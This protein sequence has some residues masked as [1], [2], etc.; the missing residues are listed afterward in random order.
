MKRSKIY[1]VASTVALAVVGFISAKAHQH[2]STITVFYSSGQGLQ[3]CAL[4]ATGN[5]NKDAGT[6]VGYAT[7]SNVHSPCNTATPIYD[8]E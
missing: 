8:G 6:L 1:L 3:T 2:F 7:L 4:T 5:F